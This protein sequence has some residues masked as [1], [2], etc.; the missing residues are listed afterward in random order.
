MIDQILEEATRVAETYGFERVEVEHL[1]YVLIKQDD[2][3][4]ALQAFGLD[5]DR[6]LSALMAGFN[7]KRS[8][9]PVTPARTIISD[10]VMRI[11]ERAGEDEVGLFGPVLEH[12]RPNTRT[13]DTAQLTNTPRASDAFRM[14]GMSRLGEPLPDLDHLLEEIGGDSAGFGHL[15]DDVFQRRGAS[16]G[17]SPATGLMDGSSNPLDPGSPRPLGETE[18]AQTTQ[19]EK[20]SLSAKERTEALRAVERA[21]RDL[22]ALYHAG[23]LDP[24]LGR[25]AEIDQVCEVLMRRRK[26]NVLLVGEPGVGK[27]ALME[28][29]ASRV[30]SS[31]DPA[32]SSRPVLQA[33]LGALVAGARYRGDF[34]IRMELLLELAQDRNAILF[35]DEMQMLIGSGA[36]AERGMDGANLL[37]PALARDGLSLVGATT[38]EE[39]DVIRTDPALM[40]RFELVRLREPR[41]EL[42]REIMRGAAAPYLRHHRVGADE[43]VLD[44]IIDFADRYVPDRRFPDK[45][46][47]ILDAACVRARRSG[48]AR[49]QVEDIRDAVRRVGGRL[50]NLGTRSQE[51]TDRIRDRI[52]S[53]VSDRV[54]GHPEAIRQIADGIA[55][56]RVGEPLAFALRGEAGVG[57]RTM[58]RALGEAL[59]LRF[60]E[61]D[62]AVGPEQIRAQ[63]ISAIDRDGSVLLLLTTGSLEDR[64]FKQLMREILT[65]WSLNHKSGARLFMNDSVITLKSNTKDKIGFSIGHQEYHDDINSVW[66]IEM[67]PFSGS[68]LHDAV[69]FQ[70]YRMSRLWSDAGASRPLREINEIIADIP[71]GTTVWSDIM[72]ICERDT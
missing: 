51:E 1:L 3:G 33:S 25:D 36:T 12:F 66:M 24:V 4:A 29:V 13:D 53:E 41:P 60:L 18:R 56:R 38:T 43:R 19:T 10:P 20:P 14:S 27:T 17:I 30:A 39:L 71:P 23:G 72:A 2:T 16:R 63:L 42:M 40:R 37:K 48:R 62:A 67:P 11:L 57:R 22:T 55:Q 9:T 47:D 45:A 58:A 65:L 69:K 32:L 70:L 8:G 59:D 26:S 52:I 5:P 7:F 35:I 64:E 49:L 61:L 31:P 68:R 21:I 6:I 46:F 54:G 15:C 34:E 50:P 28:G 44:R